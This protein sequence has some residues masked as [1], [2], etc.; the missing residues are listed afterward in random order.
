MKKL[1]LSSIGIAIFLLLLACGSHKNLTMEEKRSPEELIQAGDMLYEQG[2]YKQA[3]DTYNR[4]LLFYPTS[5]L[6]IDAKL[7]I[8]RCYGKM[9]K[10]E[11]QMDVLLQLLKENLIPERVPEIYI[12]I[13]EYYEQAARFN[14]EGTKGDSVDYQTAISYYTKAYNYEDSNDEVAKSEALYRKALVEAKIGKTDDAAQTYQMI[15]NTFPESPFAVLAQIKLM[16]PKDT[17]ELSTISDSLAVYK[18]RLAQAGMEAPKAQ[19]SEMKGQENNPPSNQSIEE[20]L[21]QE[22]SKTPKT[23]EMQPAPADTAKAETP[24]EAD[25]LKK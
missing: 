7:K 12:Q 9:E 24:V 17:S 11:K 18:K 14:P 8:A 3:I 6:D 16:N 1:I 10:Y 5:D 25:S 21:N 15:A 23:E 13:G 4:L 2:N 22:G 20:Y 19:E